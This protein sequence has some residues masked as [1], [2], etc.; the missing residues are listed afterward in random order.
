MASSERRGAGGRTSE[1]GN[2]ADSAMAISGELRSQGP[3]CLRRLVPRF[4][5]HHHGSPI[6]QRLHQG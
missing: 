6:R 3:E 2:A 1:D 5:L 4:F